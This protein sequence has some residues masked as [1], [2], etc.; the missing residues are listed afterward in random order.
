MITGNEDAW[1]DN[2]HAKPAPRGHKP[3]I[4]GDHGGIPL[5]KNLLR[6]ARAKGVDIICD[7]RA[8]N[9]IKDGEMVV[10]VAAR[11]DMQVRYFKARVVLFLRRVA[12][13]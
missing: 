9:V 11:I 7:A 4:K 13:S 1:P 8:L 10:G 3:Q 6:S 5:M 12:S 2:T